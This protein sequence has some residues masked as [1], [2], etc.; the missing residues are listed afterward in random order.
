LSNFKEIRLKKLEAVCFDMDGVII[1]SEPLYAKGE[2]KL[3]GEYGV[4]IPP[5]DW[6]LFRG[7]NEQ[8]FYDL[9]MN[10]YKIT[11]DRDVFVE[12]GRKYV[13]DEF[14][15]NLD[16]MYGFK[17][18]HA[19]LNKHGIKKALVTAS[20]KEMFNYV[21]SRL[22]LTKMF[23]EIVIGGMA[24][25]NKPN[26]EPYLL[27]MEML[28]VSPQNTVVIEDSVHGINSGLSSGAFVVGYRGSVPEKELK[29]ADYIVTNHSELSVEL[30]NNKLQ[31]YNLN[32]P[33]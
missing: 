8:T 5:E 4:E 14:N 6:V 16:Y 26:P 12:K 23:D 3:F 20:P 27:A 33:S 1:D 15:K 28:N 25:K 9:S 24:K 7:C 32:K 19:S 2:I 30:L 29:I 22:G 31:N 18:F 11:E 17:T 10:R 21:D 13:M